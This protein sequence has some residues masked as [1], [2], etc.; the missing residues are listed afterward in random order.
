VYLLS[1][2]TRDSFFTATLVPLSLLPLSPSHLL[3][4]YKN[5]CKSTSPVVSDEPTEPPIGKRDGSHCCSATVFTTSHTVKMVSNKQNKGKRRVYT[6]APPF[7]LA[8][9]V[10]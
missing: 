5:T 7:P 4:E 1:T 10:G 3:N 2:R 9:L 8:K 6:G